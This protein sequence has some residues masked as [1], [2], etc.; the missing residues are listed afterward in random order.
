M[1]TATCQDWRGPAGRRGLPVREFEGAV[2][3]REA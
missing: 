3:L 2:D 1:E